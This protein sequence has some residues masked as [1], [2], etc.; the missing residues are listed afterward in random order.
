MGNKKST[1]RFQKKSKKDETPS[2]VSSHS[3]TQSNSRVM[4][5]REFHNV[6][7]STYVLPKDDFEKDRLHQVILGMNLSLD[8]FSSESN[9]SIPS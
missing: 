6:E 9:V 5:G 7:S 1:L 2:N 3:T 8:Q 4:H